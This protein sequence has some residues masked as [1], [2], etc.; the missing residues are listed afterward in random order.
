VIESKVV[1]SRVVSRVITVGKLFIF[2]FIRQ[3]KPGHAKVGRSVS[4]GGRFRKD[5]KDCWETSGSCVRHCEDR[6]VS[7][8]S[9]PVILSLDHLMIGI[10]EQ[11]HQAYQQCTLTT[12]GRGAERHGLALDCP[13]HFIELILFNSYCNHRWKVSLAPFYT[14][15]GW[16]KGD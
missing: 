3:T 9:S 11:Q 7:K 10:K 4:F 6:L 15:G 2:L 14:G 1:D 13:S 16:A 8:K 5:N 12:V